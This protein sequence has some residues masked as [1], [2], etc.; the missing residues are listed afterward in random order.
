M[1]RRTVPFNDRVHIAAGKHRAL[2]EE[3]DVEAEEDPDRNRQGAF[4]V[5]AHQA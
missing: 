3:D 2:D 4:P 5:G 1:S